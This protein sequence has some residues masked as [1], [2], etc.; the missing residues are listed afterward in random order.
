M[1]AGELAASPATRPGPPVVL[2]AEDEESLRSMLSLVLTGAGYAPLLCEDGAVAVA[3]LDRQDRLDVALLD[4][5]M[6]ELS[7]PEVLARIRRHP[8]H[9]SLPVIAMSAY[10]DELQ[11]RELLS[12][13]ADAF[14]PKP[15]SVADLGELLARFVGPR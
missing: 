4:L 8:A 15:F 6:P 3:E 9:H 14:L 13:G 2:V 7:G 11:A 10:S 1:P 5:R 12:Q